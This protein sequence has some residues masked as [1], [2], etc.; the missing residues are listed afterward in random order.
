MQKEKTG[1]TGIMAL[2]I[3]LE[4]IFDRLEWGFVRKI[5]LQF[6]FPAEL[7]T[8]IMICISSTSVSIFFNGGRL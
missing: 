8:I 1:K 5:C 4:K 6:N 3:D 2:K 7:V